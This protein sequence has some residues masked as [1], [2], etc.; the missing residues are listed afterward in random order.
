[1]ENS[2][3]KFWLFSCQV[4]SGCWV[5]TNTTCC[6]HSDPMMSGYRCGNIRIGA[7][8]YDQ[9]NLFI[10]ECFQSLP[11]YAVL[12]FKSQFMVEH[13]FSLPH[14]IGQLAHANSIHNSDG[15]HSFL[16]LASSRHTRLSVA[17]RYQ[18]HTHLR[19]LCPRYSF[20][21]KQVPTDLWRGQCFLAEV[22]SGYLTWISFPLG[23]TLSDLSLVFSL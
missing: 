18:A 4:Q 19:G 21:L 17:E 5:P 12:K 8:I 3:P 1:M 20:N 14:V 22:F 2:P 13:P 11:R 16:T 10:Y 7:V 6:T 15:P 23:C 9:T